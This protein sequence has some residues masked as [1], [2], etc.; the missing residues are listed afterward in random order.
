MKM[1]ENAQKLMPLSIF[2]ASLLAL[3]PTMLPSTAQS[4]SAPNSQAA[5]DVAAKAA[6]RKKK[7][8]EEKARLEGT[9]RP[10]QDPCASGKPVLYIT[11][12]AASMLV[13]ES[14]GFTLFDTE[15]H[16]LTAAADW[17]I[18]NSSYATLTKGTEPTV[19]AKS[20]GEFI[21]TATV[22]SRTAEAKIKV[23]PGT[24]LPIGTERWH[25]APVPCSNNPNRSRISKVVAASPH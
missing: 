4:S 9:Q 19:T 6:A 15:G 13:G 18:S 20:E 22:D 2:L 24:E 21:L 23:Y 1:L 10:Q 8:E 14:R 3:P 25:V 7:F 5:D 12:T 16:K 17:S 11:P